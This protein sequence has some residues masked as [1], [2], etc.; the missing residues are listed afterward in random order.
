FAVL[1]SGVSAQ[2]QAV[3]DA[4]IKALQNQINQLQATVKQ[5]EAQQEKSSAE[6]K[7][8][9]QAATH[10]EVQAAQ[11]RQTAVPPP[12]QVL[13]LQTKATET[14]SWYF[15]HKPGSA[16]TFQTP[17]GEITGYGNLD[18]SFDAGSKNVGK[19]PL[20]GT[21]P[22][23]NFGWM[24]DISTNTSY[25]GLRGFQ[26]IPHQDF[27]FVYQLEAGFEIS[28]TPGTAE[29]GSADH[30]TVNGALFNRNSFVGVASP[31]YGALKIGK[32]TA[33]YASSTA[34]FNPFAG[35]FGDYAD[36][37]GNTGGDLRAEFG[38]RLDHAVW[39]ES[40]KMGGWQF[41]ALFAPGQNRSLI[42]D[43]IAS[44]EVE[45]TGGD[46]PQSGGDSPDACNDGAYSNAF[47]TNLSYTNGGFYTTAAYEWH[48]NV[49]RQSDITA[50]YGAAGSNSTGC[51]N[52]AGGTLTAGQLADC[53]A[54]FNQDVADEWATKAGALY[55]FSTG[56]TIGGIV[57][58]MHRDVPADLLFQNERTRLG[59]WAFVSQ[60]VTKVD[61]V[62][63]GWAH[64]FK[65]P[66]DPGQHNDVTLTTPDGGAGYATNQN[67]ADMVTA[68][69]KH[70]LMPGLI[71]YNDVAAIFNGNSAHYALGAGGARAVSIDCHDAVS[72]DGGYGPDVGAPGANCYTG[73]TIVGVS[74]GLQY[75]F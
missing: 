75:K 17:G 7:A 48:Q 43:N 40:P 61:S 63:F 2:A 31:A 32:T 70:Q 54:L 14:D 59:T 28:A 45:C 5:L 64:A 58:Y 29:S 33:P 49:N 57:E 34:A 46:T 60:Q 69:W 15:R 27:N 41:N 21:S 9:K 42:S 38:T 62:H 68:L 18:V 66:G 12:G 39:Y 47:S 56:T 50:I 44:G 35:T 10:A 52:V 13:N 6:A 53:T 25:F 72:A 71:W 19:M 30:N 23:G 24:P 74:T 3:S 20:N 22:L 55:K 51:S 16:L 26:R 67:Q 11:A 36:V 37:M 4:Q 8:A 1:G 65:T 73:T